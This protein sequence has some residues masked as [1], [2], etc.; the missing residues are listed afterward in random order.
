MTWYTRVTEDLSL[1]PDFIA[2]YENELDAASS[3]VRIRG[4]IEQNLAALPGITDHRF[5][6]L[7]VVEAVLDYLNTELRKIKSKHFK[8]YLENYQRA[9]TSRDVERYVDG[10]QEVID[11][12]MLV[13]EVALLRNRYLGVIKGLEAK[14]WQLGHIVRLRTAGMEDITI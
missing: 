12:L 8:R 10:E 1:L 14:Q 9:L 6:Q 11:M 5:Q 4:K 7:Q 3:E 2:H 13:N